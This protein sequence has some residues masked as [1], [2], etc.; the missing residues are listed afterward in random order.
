MIFRIP[1]LISHISSIITL[2]EGDVILTG[3]AYLLFPVQL[4]KCK[5]LTTTKPWSQIFWNRLWILNK[6]LN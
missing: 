2:L 5:F 1:F 3:T 6:L 4:L